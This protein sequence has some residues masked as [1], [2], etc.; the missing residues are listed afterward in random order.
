MFHRPY[1]IR[2]FTGRAKRAFAGPA[3]IESLQVLLFPFGHDLNSHLHRR[4]R[5]GRDGLAGARTDAGNMPSIIDDPIRGRDVLDEVERLAPATEGLLGRCAE[6][7][8]H[9]RFVIAFHRALLCKLPVVAAPGMYGRRARTRS[10]Y[11][12]GIGI[13]F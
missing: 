3:K 4:L 1:E 8:R 12:A 13:V 2:V 6:I 9:V 11:Q 7:D 10:L 5:D